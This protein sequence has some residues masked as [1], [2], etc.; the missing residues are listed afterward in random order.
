MNKK[1]FFETYNLVKKNIYWFNPDLDI[2][3]KKYI[4]KT[5]NFKFIDKNELL[6][7]IELLK[8]FDINLLYNKQFMGL[9]VSDS[10][11]AVASEPYNFLKRLN[12]DYYSEILK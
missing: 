4:E 3:T 11:C 10:I 8:N 6:N 5:E 9:K 2:Q 7:K 1:D 12:N